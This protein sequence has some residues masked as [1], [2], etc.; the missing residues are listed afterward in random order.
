LKTGEGKHSPPVNLAALR[1]RHF[2]FGRCVKAEAAAVFAA[3]LDFGSRSTFEAADA[4]FLLVTSPDF[5]LVTEITRL[6]SYPQNPQAWISGGQFQ[7]RY[8]RFL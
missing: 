7:A 2:L 6:S 1:L 4:A 8:C 5:P 3:A